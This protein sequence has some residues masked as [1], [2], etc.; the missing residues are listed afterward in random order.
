[1]RSF[2]FHFCEVVKDEIHVVNEFVKL[3]VI[4]VQLGLP[5]IVMHFV[6]SICHVGHARSL[7]IDAWYVHNPQSFY[8]EV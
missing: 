7:P 6:F 3:L 5:G 8:Q 2:N 4:T 1:M